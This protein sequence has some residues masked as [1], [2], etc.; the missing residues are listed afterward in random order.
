MPKNFS[1]TFETMEPRSKAQAS[2]QQEGTG[3]RPTRK[4]DSGKVPTH[5]SSEVAPEEVKGGKEALSIKLNP[6]PQAHEFAKRMQDREE[7]YPNQHKRLTIGHE[8]GWHIKFNQ[9]C[10][11]KREKKKRDTRKGRKHSSGR[12]GSRE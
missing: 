2:Q 1:K 8:M 12:R 6:F 4:V 10:L 9:N 11:H 5:A 7:E 3:A